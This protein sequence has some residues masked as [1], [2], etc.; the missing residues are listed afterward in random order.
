[1]TTDD[2]VAIKVTNVTKT[3]HLPHEK[4][5]TIKSAIIN[6]RK[7]HNGHEK[8]IALDDVSF[9]VKKG[10]FY[11]IIGRNGS[12]KS[13]LLKLLAG[14]YT[15]DKGNIEVNGKLTPFIELG[16]G[17]NQELTGRD[18]VFLN[19]ALLG[20]DRSE[21][22]KM[23]NDIVEF[24]ELEQ[25]MDQKL[26]NYSSGMQVRLA[27]SIAIRAESDILLLDEVLAVGD[28]AFQRKCV[29][30]FESLKKM[31]KTVVFVTHDM[32]SVEKFCTKV[33]VVDKSKQVGIYNPLD[34][35]NIYDE[36]NSGG[37][38]K[39]EPQALSDK[40]QR[41]PSRWGSG[42][43]KIKSIEFMTDQKL[44]DGL[45]LPL[46]H[47]RPLTIRINFNKKAEQLLVG[48]AVYD[49][50]D[51]N[52]S[53]PN[54]GMLDLSGKDYVEYVI[55][56]LSLNQGDYYL[57]M[58]LFNPETHEEIDYIPKA[59]RFRVINPGAQK[60]GKVELFGTWRTK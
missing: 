10:E 4:S 3:F 57:A 37:V 43:I 31:K 14:I 6:F 48:F 34:A 19:G 60:F 2:D 53:G 45:K 40:K 32:A 7:R 8:Q 27:F 44:V 59:A 5:G 22:K 46:V 39:T 55:D 26:K 30:Y 15:P 23:Y 12:G 49:D 58:G 38:Q 50:Q 28:M 20:F 51:T 17:F 1:M 29:R 16:V 18:N 47:D 42:S 13:T 54:S 24:A 25:F 11:G 33:L 41:V 35:K 36:I 56:R 21:M 9:E 52:L